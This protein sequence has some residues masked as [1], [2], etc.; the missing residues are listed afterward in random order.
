MNEELIVPS[1]GQE[2]TYAFGNG[3]RPSGRPKYKL[4]EARYVLSAKT[5]R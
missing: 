2:L 1:E 5:K 3:K 4:K